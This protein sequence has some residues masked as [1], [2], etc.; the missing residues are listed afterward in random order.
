MI[1]EINLASSSLTKSN[2][3]ANGTDSGAGGDPLSQIVRV[4]NSHLAQLQQI[5]SG[6]AALQQRVNA[7]QKEA[8]GL[9]GRAGLGGLGLD[10]GFMRSMGRR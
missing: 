8:R 7:A 9:G 4:L 3:A 5:D 1:E 2:K 6:A 10:D